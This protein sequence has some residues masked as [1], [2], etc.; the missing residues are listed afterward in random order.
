MPQVTGEKIGHDPMIMPIKERK[1]ANVLIV[2]PQF[3]RFAHNWEVSESLKEMLNV[4]T[5]DYTN[6]SDIVN[7]DL[8]NE[9]FDA[10]VRQDGIA[11]EEIYK[12]MK[13]NGIKNPE[14]YQEKMYVSE[15]EYAG[16]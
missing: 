4:D 6:I 10:V 5:I 8:S 15:L 3:T 7:I 16:K 13:N 11:L 9:K 12:T 1:K 14:L 2:D